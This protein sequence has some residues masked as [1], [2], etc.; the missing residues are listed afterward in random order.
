[1]IVDPS[2]QCLKGFTVASRDQ[3]ASMSKVSAVHHM[4]FALTS[5][6][7]QS[8]RI[9]T[10]NRLKVVITGQIQTYAVMVT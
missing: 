9:E 1:M 3:L 7:L 6:F 2:P 8:Q 5:P 10:S 4:E